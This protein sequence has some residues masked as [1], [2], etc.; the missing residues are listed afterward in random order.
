[1]IFRFRIDSYDFSSYF[2]LYFD[3]CLFIFLVQ[4]IRNHKWCC[5]KFKQYPD[6]IPLKS[7]G[8]LV[9]EYVR[10]EWKNR[11][12]NNVVGGTKK[13]NC[14]RKNFMFAFVKALINKIILLYVYELY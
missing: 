6:L 10:E 7:W 14:K 9:N 3:D 13:S 8:S 5:G 4:N 2:V 12:C 1:M 11:D